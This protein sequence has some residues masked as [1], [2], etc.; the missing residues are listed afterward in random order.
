MTILS[1]IRREVHKARRERARKR[2]LGFPEPRLVILV[3]NWDAYTAE[4][5]H[6][7]SPESWAMLDLTTFEGCKVERGPFSGVGVAWRS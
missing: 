4:R 1:D 2:S 7:A 6:E 3:G 5:A